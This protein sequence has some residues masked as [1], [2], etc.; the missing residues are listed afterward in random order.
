MALYFIF[1]H[2]N[3]EIWV[4]FN[5]GT[6]LGVKSSTTNVKYIDCQGKLYRY[7]SFK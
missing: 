4:K 2:S 5:D 1:Q 6:Q 7:V 3:G